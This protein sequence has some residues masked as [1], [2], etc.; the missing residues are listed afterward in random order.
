MYL[1]SCLLLSSLALP[2]SRWSHLPLLIYF[3]RHVDNLQIGASQFEQQAARLK[4]KYW[5]QNLKMMI[6]MGIIVGVILI[7]VIGER[8]FFF[9]N[10]FFLHL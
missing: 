3:L 10:V 9:F 6:I 8:F 7:I 4:R 2:T 5:W 1:T